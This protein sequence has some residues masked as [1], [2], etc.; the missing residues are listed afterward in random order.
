MRPITQPCGVFM[1]I[2]IAPLTQ[3][4]YGGVFAVLVTRRVFG[5]WPAGSA[6]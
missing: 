2:E 3:V 4:E 6:A 5:L 1:L